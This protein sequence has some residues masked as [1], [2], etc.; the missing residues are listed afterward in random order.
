MGRPLRS[1]G[2]DLQSMPKSRSEADRGFKLGDWAIHPHTNLACVVLEWCTWGRSPLDPMKV[3]YS[4]D[5]TFDESPLGFKIIKP[6]RSPKLP[7]WVK[8]GR[9]I[10]SYKREDEDFDFLIT[11]IRGQYVRVDLDGFYENMQEVSHICPRLIG[12]FPLED[13]LF[14]FD[15]QLTRHERLD[16]D[17]FLFESA[18][19]SLAPQEAASK[20]STS[21]RW[22]RILATR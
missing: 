11:E 20:G 9:R 10:R 8:C 1:I 13:L 2:G 12:I 19:R 7:S 6:R 18:A 15:V 3:C 21:S 4:W 5:E 22:H 16:S 14:H 17:S